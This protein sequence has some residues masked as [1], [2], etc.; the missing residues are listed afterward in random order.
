[1]RRPI[2]IGV[3]SGV[4]LVAGLA[5]L[6]PGALTAS[7][8]E[9]NSCASCHVMESKVASFQ[10]SNSLHKTELSCSDCHLPE[11]VD[12]LKE[13]YKVGFRHFMVNLK[14]EA[15]EHISLRAQDRDWVVP[16]VCA[17]TPAPTMCSR[18]ARTPA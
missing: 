2:L 18:L 5:L 6:G 16:T 17:A 4:A 10:S 9:P 12:G 14:G 13:K 7:G 15:P 8:L 11:G 3:V 1:M